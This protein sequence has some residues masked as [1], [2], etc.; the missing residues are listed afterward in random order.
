[1]NEAIQNFISIDH[2]D[3]KYSELNSPISVK[4]CKEKIFYF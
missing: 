4:K 1:M 3:T 2:L